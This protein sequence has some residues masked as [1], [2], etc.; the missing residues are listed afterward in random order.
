MSK[1]IGATVGTT[2]SPQKVGERLNTVTSINGTKPDKN[3]DVAVPTPVKVTVTQQP[4]GSYTADLRTTQI[5]AAYQAGSAV[6]CC[7]GQLVLDLSYAALA[8]CI[9][10][11]IYN[12]RLHII[13]VESSGTTVSDTALG[14]GDGSD[15]ITPHIGAN[16]NWFIGDTDTG[17]PSRGEAGPKGDT[18]IQGPVGPQGE[19]GDPGI[20][21]P[22]G[23]QGEKGDKGD[24]GKDGQDGSPGKDGANGQP[25]T[26]GAD[27]VSVTHKWVGT[28]LEVTSAAG[29][30]SVDLKGEKGEV[31]ATGPQGE[32]G[33]QGEKGDKGD[34]GDTGAAGPQGEPGKDGE[35]GEQG[36]QGPKGDR[37]DTGATG[38]TGPQGDKGEKGDKGD[39]GPK[40]DT[41]AT[42]PQGPTG[43]KGADGKTPVKGT[44]YWTSADQEAI[45]QQVIAAFGTPVFGMVDANN[46]IILTGELA[47]GTYT[48]KYEGVDG[49]QTE[50]GY[51][52][53]GGATYTNQLDE[54]G[55]ETGYRLSS[56]GEPSAVTGTN[57]TFITGYIRV[58]DQQ[59]VRLKNCYI[60]V[61]G[62]N[63]AASA[64]TTAYYGKGCSSLM[65]TLCNASKGVMNTIAWNGFASS[66][67][68]KDVVQDS[69]GHITQFKINRSGIVYIRLTLGGD[70]PNAI[71]TLDQEITD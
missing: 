37:G 6:Y 39:T 57:P 27:G 15:G 58:D 34:K 36:I 63:G 48:L 32:Q 53:V 56:S 47:D 1:I 68:I 43:A 9:F 4:D 71:L 21:G 22:E 11:C 28:V 61:D 44:D 49:E 25:G 54:F 3:G 67:Y 59:V 12:G 7:C 46:N 62:I 29:T 20:T 23:P 18:G 45:V 8:R 17:M 14:S 5:V 33:P 26:D 19:K 42:G 38:A 66:D 10:T 16:G 70:A 60:D 40:G 65:V 35:Q 52:K 41:G 50:I 55:Y 31:G 2:M 13:S 30:S 64:E 51:I 69:N 24:P